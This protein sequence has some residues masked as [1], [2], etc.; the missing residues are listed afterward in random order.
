MTGSHISDEPIWQWSGGK[1]Y[2]RSGGDVLD[3]RSMILGWTAVKTEFYLNPLSPS[4]T[5]T[6]A[7][8]YPQQLWL[9]TVATWALMA[10]M[11]KMRTAS[12]IAAW[13]TE[14][15]GVWTTSRAYILTAW[16]NSYIELRSMLI[17]SWSNSIGSVLRPSWPSTWLCTCQSSQSSRRQ[18]IWL[19][20]STSE[21]STR[22]ILAL[23]G[24][25]TNILLV[26]RKQ[27][28][29]EIMSLPNLSMGKIWNMG[30]A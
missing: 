5:D 28:G 25:L 13:P 14:R 22:S 2:R 11:A 29:K 9:S 4:E 8:Q 18:V 17:K 6:V 21:S 12:S 16:P 24:S 10:K 3:Q 20:G 19:V 15:A 27:Q 7:E 30:R 26:P 1:P 23:I